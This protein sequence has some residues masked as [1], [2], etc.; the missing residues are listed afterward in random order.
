MDSKVR[1]EG[2]GPFHLPAAQDVPAMGHLNV[3]VTLTFLLDTGGGGT[4]T[5]AVNVKVDADLALRLCSYLLRA[6]D[7]SL[8]TN[9]R[10][11]Q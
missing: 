4:E 11:G 5:S 2:I 6:I 9:A 8:G 7:E 3:G 10:V 1:F